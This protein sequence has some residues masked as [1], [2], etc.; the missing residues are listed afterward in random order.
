MVR[1]RG[2]GLRVLCLGFRVCVLGFMLG[3]KVTGILN[4]ATHELIEKS[5]AASLNAKARTLNSKSIL[6]LSC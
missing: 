4:L 3:S 1:V 2:Q 5:G 6:M